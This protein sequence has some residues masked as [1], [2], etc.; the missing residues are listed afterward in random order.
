MPNILDIRRR[1]RSVRNTQQITKAMKMVSAA[2]LRRA[3]EAVLNARPYAGQILK[4]VRS[5][6]AR[7]ETRPHPLLAER[8][9]Q[10]IQL[11][12]ITAD[13]GLCGAF[14]ANIVKVAEGFIRERVDQSIDLFCVGRKGR[15]YFGKRTTPIGHQQV[16]L[17]HRVEFGHAREITGKLVSQFLSGERDAVY[18]LYNEFKSVIQQ[19]IVVER[20]LPIP[21]MLL[22]SEQTP[23][24]YIYEQ[25]A[26]EILNTLMPKH[27]EVQVFRALLES[28]AAEHGARMT[29]MD[30]A[31][32]NAVE[33]IE[34]L[35]LTMNRARQAGITNEI[36]EVVSG[37]AALK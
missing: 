3:Q 23:V 22:S 5:L 33:M 21:P 9:E 36:I 20:L 26:V 7:S 24:D 27:V 16:N 28:S 37:A 14:N 34:S 29:A 19:R 30:A 12:V 1:I 32:N 11:V 25:P 18:L 17:F 10:K 35:T 2:K 4:V 8:E 6:M 15:D 31:T 13:K